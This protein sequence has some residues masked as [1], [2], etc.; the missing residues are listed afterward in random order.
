MAPIVYAMLAALFGFGLAGDGLT[1]RVP[2]NLQQ[3]TGP[4]TSVRV[5]V[6]P[7]PTPRLGSYQQVTVRIN[8]A[9]AR[10]LPLATM[11]P[12]PR[13][14]TPKGR[15]DQLEL[16]ATNV[17]L[18]ALRASEVKLVAH[19]LVY[20]LP[21]ALTGHTLRVTRLG[22][23][24]LTVRFA[25]GDLDAYAAEF[26]PELLEP[27]VT[28]ESGRFVMRALLPLFI[29]AFPVTI[30]GELRVNMQRQILLRNASLETGRVEFS[31]EVIE[32][33]LARFDPLVD[34]DELLQFSAP[35][36]WQRA[37]T[38]SGWC[39]ITGRLETPSAPP[40]AHPFEPR[41]R[42]DDLF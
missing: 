6:Q 2:R 36:D 19:D 24:Q 18:D 28:F 13:P 4:G 11:L 20:D 42:Y 14:G 41:Q 26:F 39:V 33:L 23:Q 31:G 7:G 22:E 21:T 9:D 16:L 5:E 32:A 15:I 27:H 37:E 25:D 12:R 10:D 40:P 34:L 1:T 17:H 8:G 29:A 3:M 30:R 35:L 38:G